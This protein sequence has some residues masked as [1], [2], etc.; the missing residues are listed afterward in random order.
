MAKDAIWSIITIDIF[1]LIN[2]LKIIY[3]ILFV[4]AVLGL[5]C[6]SDFVLYFRCTSFSTWWLLLVQITGSRTHR[7]QELQHVG[8]VVAV[9]RV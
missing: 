3:S 8:S 1:L 6:C 9:P 4:W 7:L 5:C 2:H